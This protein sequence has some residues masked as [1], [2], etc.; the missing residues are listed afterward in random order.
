M[1]SA[2]LTAVKAFVSQVK[3]NLFEA[4]KATVERNGYEVKKVNKPNSK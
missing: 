4:A 2:T 3:T 1:K